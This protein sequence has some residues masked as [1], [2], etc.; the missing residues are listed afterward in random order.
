MKN[1]NA[2][3]TRHVIFP[4][5][6]NRQRQDLEEK[7]S[8]VQP[9]AVELDRPEPPMDVQLGGEAADA[10]IQAW[11][12]DLHHIAVGVKAESGAL[13]EEWDKTLRESARLL[14]MH[15]GGGRPYLLTY[16]DT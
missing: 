3:S 9:P 8:D 1:S 14:Q 13:A 6:L 5:T 12:K 10:D 7:S 16:M 11:V 2:A 4:Q 15:E